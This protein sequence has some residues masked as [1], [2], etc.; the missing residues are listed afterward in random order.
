M[1]LVGYSRNGPFLIFGVQMISPC[2]ISIHLILSYLFDLSLFFSSC[3]ANILLVGNR[4][5]LHPMFD[6]FCGNKDFQL[7]NNFLQFH[8]LPHIYRYIQ[9]KHQLNLKIQLQPHNK[10]KFRTQVRRIIPK[11]L[12]KDKCAHRQKSHKQ[13]HQ[14]QFHFSKSQITQKPNHLK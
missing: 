13:I 6:Q 9:C 10:R 5:A 3:D 11:F 2:I 12:T 4:N 14:R 7:H 1:E 8:A